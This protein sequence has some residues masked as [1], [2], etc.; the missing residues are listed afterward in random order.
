MDLRETGL[1]GV[2]WIQPSQDR[3]WWRV[4]VSAVMNLQVLAPWI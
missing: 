2:D 3:D 1:G 4:V